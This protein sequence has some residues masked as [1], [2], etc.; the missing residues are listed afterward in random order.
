MEKIHFGAIT[1]TDFYFYPFLCSI[2]KY[3]LMY[4][5]VKGKFMLGKAK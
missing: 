4:W 2:K 3:L 1:L 5:Y